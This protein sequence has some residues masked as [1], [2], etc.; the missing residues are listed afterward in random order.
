MAVLFVFIDGVGAGA[1]DPS[2]NPLARHEFLLSQFSDGS[3]APLPASGRAVL[4]DA[5]LGVSGRPQS[6]TGQT[7]ILTG[8]NAARAIGKHLLGFP[9]E[10][11]RAILRARSLFRALAEAG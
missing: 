6:A 1:R 11:L 10:S 2:L 9:N 4:A 5:C 8:E 3:G 7:S